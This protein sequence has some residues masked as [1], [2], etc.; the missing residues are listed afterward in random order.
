MSV[1]LPNER[2]YMVTPCGHLF[3]QNCLEQ[4]MVRSHSHVGRRTLR[5]PNHPALPGIQD[6]VP[7]LPSAIA[8]PIATGNR[9]TK[10]FK[11]F[12]GRAQP[13][14]EWGLFTFPTLWPSSPPMRDYHRTA[15]KFCM[16][17]KEH[18]KEFFD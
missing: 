4:W 2:D 3:H 13:L 11:D 17:H 5:Q 16:P 14:Q 9:E 8:L 1:V 7:N 15:R 12:F 10:L 6:G 18:R